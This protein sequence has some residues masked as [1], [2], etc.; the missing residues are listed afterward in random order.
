MQMQRG[1]AKRKKENNGQMITENGNKRK[2]TRIDR[3]KE[4]KTYK[5]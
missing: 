5:Q 2:E 1:E 4:R 3:S